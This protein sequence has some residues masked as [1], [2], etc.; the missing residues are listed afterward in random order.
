LSLDYFYDDDYYGDD[1]LPLQLCQGDCVDDSDC[2]V[3]LKCL[4]RNG[5]APIPG[6]SGNGISGND[7]CIYPEL[8]DFGFTPPASQL[9]LHLCQGR[10]IGRIVDGHIE[11]TWWEIQGELGDWVVWG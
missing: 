1:D 4:L 11:C 2:A 9:P 8:K 3:G 6:C 10:G 5:F 7:V